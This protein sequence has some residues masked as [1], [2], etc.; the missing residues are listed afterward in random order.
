MQV[1][2]TVLQFL[3]KADNIR[4]SYTENLW[5]LLNDL[6]LVREISR[7]VAA[8]W[9]EANAMSAFD[10]A[11]IYGEIGQR[12][13]WINTYSIVY[14]LANGWQLLLKLYITNASPPIP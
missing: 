12:G 8:G 11:D 3:Q 7:V 2:R 9:P 14:E 5:Q 13:V 1:S 10:V 6:W 4:H